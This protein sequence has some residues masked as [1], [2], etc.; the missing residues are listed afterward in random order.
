ME[1][2]FLAK[3][4]KNGMIQMFSIKGLDCV[5]IL[6]QLNTYVCDVGGR[7]GTLPTSPEAFN[8][9]YMNSKGNLSSEKVSN[10]MVSRNYI[11]VFNKCLYELMCQFGDTL[12][13]CFVFYR[14][15]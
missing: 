4:M 3:F 9:C 15:I 6:L 8:K 13:Y 2:S 11:I 7:D 1:R 5:V 14:I 10:A 12:R